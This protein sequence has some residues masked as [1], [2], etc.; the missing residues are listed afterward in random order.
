MIQVAEKE[1]KKEGRF[2]RLFGAKDRK[3][4]SEDFINVFDIEKKINDSIQSPNSSAQTD[5]SAELTEEDASYVP[6]TENEDDLPNLRKIFG[7]FRRV[8]IRSQC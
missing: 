4:E 5:E 1:T 3:N 7:K 8:N 2:S 6:E